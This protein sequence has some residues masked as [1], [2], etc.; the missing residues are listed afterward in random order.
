[1]LKQLKNHGWVTSGIS[2]KLFLLFWSWR[3]VGF[4]IGWLG[5]WPVEVFKD[6]PQFL[7]LCAT[8]HVWCH[9][10]SAAFLHMEWLGFLP[11]IC[12]SRGETAA[13]DSSGTI[14]II[15]SWG[16]VFCHYWAAV[17]K[18]SLGFFT[19]DERC[20]LQQLGS[21]YFLSWT[22]ILTSHNCRCIPVANGVYFAALSCGW[23][24]GNRISS[25]TSGSAICY[26][27][28]CIAGAPMGGA[29]S[30]WSRI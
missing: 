21:L 18:A 19:F 22:H 10:F 23:A 1:M 2:E 11:S 5:L 17:E 28:F 7:W 8:F 26:L 3:A 24:A 15:T 16:F 6:I 27:Q 20:E 9:S 29:T 4:V 30:V 14:T 13:E 12:R 25:S